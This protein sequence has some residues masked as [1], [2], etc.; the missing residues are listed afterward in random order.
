MQFPIVIGSH[1]FL[2][3]VCLKAKVFAFCDSLYDE[4]DAFHNAIREPLVSSNHT[5]TVL[6]I[7]LFSFCVTYYYCC[8]TSSQIQKFIALWNIIITPQMSYQIDFNEF[9]ARYPPV[10]KQDNR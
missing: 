5:I 7:E 4:G 6:Q 2:F 10:P 9:Q 1:W 3:S 8:F